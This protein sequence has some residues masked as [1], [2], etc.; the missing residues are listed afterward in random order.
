MFVRAAEGVSRLRIAHGVRKYPGSLGVDSVLRDQVFGYLDDVDKGSAEIIQFSDALFGLTG[1]VNVATIEH[2]KI[3]LE[4]DPTITV[5]PARA[6]GVDHTEAIQA[7]MTAFIPF[8]LVPHLIE[9]RLSAR[10]AFLIVEA[11]LTPS[12]TSC[13]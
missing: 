5:I 4:A 7:R 2:H 6:D 8:S 9:K 10:E 3:T 12:W 13:E 1:A 11:H